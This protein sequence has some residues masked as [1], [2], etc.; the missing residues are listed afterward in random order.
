MTFIQEKTPWVNVRDFGASP[1]AS[2][3]NNSAAFSKALLAISG[4]GGVLRVPAGNYT[5]DAVSGSITPPSNTGLWFD[6]GATVTVETNNQATYA[7][8]L[9]DNVSN[10]H[11]W[12]G[13]IVGDRYSH[14][15]VT[16][17]SGNG[18]F[19]AGSSDVT[20]EDGY[21]R[22]CWGDGIHIDSSVNESANVSIFSVRCDRNRRNGISCVSCAGLVI[23]GCQLTNSGG[24]NVAWSNS[25][26]NMEFLDPVHHISNVTINDCDIS[27]NSG[28]G[29]RIEPNSWEVNLTNIQISNNHVSGCGSDGPI[30]RS[31][32]YVC[33]LYTNLIV[34]GNHLEDL[35]GVTADVL[36]L[37]HTM[38]SRVVNNR[39]EG[40]TSTGI[41]CNNVFSSII[42][43]NYI[44]SAGKV[45]LV[46]GGQDDVASGNYFWNNGTALDVSHCEHIW[47][48]TTSVRNIITENR[49]QRS[50][51]GGGPC[52]A[53]CV[54]NEADAVVIA[55]NL[56]YFGSTSAFLL[57]TGVGTIQWSGNPFM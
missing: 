48:P 17:F 31:Q 51:G 40:G 1:T 55:H 54:R 41:F 42:E 52:P 35:G 50:G 4:T 56:A 2:A 47:N 5:I 3:A 27:G 44:G 38:G 12:G 49:F 33:G 57:D 15:G 20:I 39:I 19:V 28:W 34:E 43:G 36:Y 32:V 7:A 9:I 16:G 46:F 14:T 29:I 18:I 37:S 11:V 10:V 13:E 53:Y 21:I 26:I 23:Q 30:S 24:G 6:V 45:G 22:N 25:G 8:I